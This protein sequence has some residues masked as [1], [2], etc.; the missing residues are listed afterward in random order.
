MS[1]PLVRLRLRFM[2]LLDVHNWKWVGEQFRYCTRPECVVVEHR[3]DE[4]HWDLDVCD[5]RFVY[6]FTIVNP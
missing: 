6:D 4:G 3:S 5:T 1:H 2:C